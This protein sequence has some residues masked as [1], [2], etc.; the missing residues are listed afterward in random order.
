M[1]SNEQQTVLN[2]V[3]T[4]PPGVPTSIPNQGGL[5]VLDC[6]HPLFLSPSDISDIQIILFQLTRIE[7][8]SLWFRSMRMALLGRNKL[9]LVDG[10]CTKESYPENLWNHWERVNAIVLSWLM[11]SV[12]SGLLGGILYASSAQTIW[13]DLH[14]RFDKVDGSRSYNLH[15]EIATLSQGATSVSAYF[16]RLKNLWEEF[17]ALVPAPGCNCPKSR[18]FVVHLQKLKLFQFLM[19]LNDSCGQARSQILLM[20]PMPSVSQAYAMV[21]SDE[22]Q[23]SVANNVGLLGANPTSGTNQY[24]VA[25][26]TKTG[27]NNQR[28]TRKNFNLFCEGNQVSSSNWNENSTQNSQLTSSAMSVNNPQNIGQANNTPWMANCTFTKEQYDH[29]VQLLN[30]DNSASASTIATPATNATGIPCALLASN[31]LQEWI[32]DT[33][34]TNHMELFSGRVKAI[35]REDSGLYILSRKKLPGNKAISLNTKEIEISKKVSSNDIDLWHRRLGHVSATVLKNLLSANAQDISAR[36]DLLDDFSRMTRIFLL[37]LKSDVCVVVQQFFTFV[38]T[39]FGA[40]VKTV[41]NDNGTEFVNLVCEN[42]FKNL[43]VIHQ[44][45]CPYTPQQ[46]GV[47]ERKHRHILELTRAIRFQANIPI[48]LWGYCVLTAVYII[49]RLP[50]SVIDNKSP[51]ERLYNKKPT[52][53]HLKVISCLCYAEMV[54]QNDKLMP[55]AKPSVHMGYVTGHKGYV[56]YDLIDKRFFVSRDV[57][58]REDIFPFKNKQDNNKLLL[59]ITDPIPQTTTLEDH[60]YSNQQE[61]S[62]TPDTTQEFTQYFEPNST[63]VVQTNNQQ[64]STLQQTDQIPQSITNRLNIRKSGRGNKSPIWMKDFVSLT[65]QQNEPYAI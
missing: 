4:V 42:F 51:Y 50:S 40:I 31:T 6:N 57:Q 52:L 27:G 35:G 15:K 24:D 44:K 45:T 3:P 39:Q 18:E 58:F 49:N 36:L 1:A 10:S 46:N 41:R 9:G 8:Y 28:M 64:T 56:L 48:K 65:A 61:D 32:I 30:K 19:G 43:G 54:N 59:H 22:S 23:K 29:I 17:E 33:G 63:E 5:H 14:E 25:M 20:N 21:I 13:N 38:K 11:N 55:R 7:N 53:Q 34:A 2:G 16:S 47:A 12:S 37:K 26:Y 62:I 60:M